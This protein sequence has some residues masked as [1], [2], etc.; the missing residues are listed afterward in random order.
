MLIGARAEDVTEL[1]TFDEG[2]L[3]ADWIGEL[4]ARHIAVRRDLSRDAARDV[5]HRYAARNGAAY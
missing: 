1:S 5:F 4:R 3:P 2:P